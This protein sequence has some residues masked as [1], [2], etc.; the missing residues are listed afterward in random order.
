MANPAHDRGYGGEQSMGF[1][2]GER[3]YFLVDGPSGAGGHAVNAAGFDGVAF[4]PTTGHMVIYDNKA[5]K[6]DGNVY[7]A[8]AISQNLAQNL[9][10]LYTRVSARSDIPQ[11]QTILAN[12]N[13]ARAALA[14][15]SGGSW[16]KNVQLAVSN[17]SG[18][19]SGVGGK[20]AN[21]TIAF[22]DYYAA[23]ST[24][25][26]TPATPIPISTPNTSASTGK[27]WMGPGGTPGFNPSGI[28]GIG[29]ALGMLQKW[30]E[31]WSMM[32]AAYAA[33]NE[34]QLREDEIR[35]AQNANVLFPVYIRIYWKV[36]FENNP[37][38]PKTYQYFGADIQN[39]ASGQPASL[40]DS[41]QHSYLMVV[42][43]LKS[44]GPEVVSHAPATWRDRYVSVLGLLQGDRSVGK[45]PVAALHVLNGSS[46]YDILAMLK[47]LKTNEP[48][49]FDKAQQAIL[50]PSANVGRERLTAAFI[51]VRMS[52]TGN[53]AFQTYANSCNEY[54][55][56]PDDQKK[57]IEEFLSPASK[58]RIDVVESPAGEWTVH[59]ANWLWTYQFDQ[60]GGV[61]WRDASNGMNGKGRWKASGTTM[62]IDWAASKTVEEWSVPLD[63]KAQTGSVRMDGK[64]YTLKATRM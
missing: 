42:P 10:G 16:P 46:M 56:L 47:T 6:R 48:F 45:D 8:T 22:I 34:I 36:H 23:P 33:W 7:S 62:R 53:T 3:G 30:A 44:R 2:W 39:G 9:D 51:A 64:H 52:E 26:A 49:L 24:T 61:T 31:Q 28:Q 43:A 63:P 50:W 38:M 12:I 27:A 4:N 13:A 55:H 15:G 11:Q 18:Q 17:A 25:P 1:Y 58:P 5:F 54:F 29:S 35:A 14:T 57:T 19:S 59:V 32:N 37:N 20:L 40:Y 60:D 41:D 21:G